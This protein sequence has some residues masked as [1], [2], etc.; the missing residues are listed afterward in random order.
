MYQVLVVLAS[1]VASKHC[2]SPV[3]NLGP[4]LFVELPRVFLYTSQCKCA[5]FT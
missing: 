5:K 3:E 4:A 2:K 1:R